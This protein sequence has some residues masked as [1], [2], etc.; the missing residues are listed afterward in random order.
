MAQVFLSYRHE[1]EEHRQRVLELGQ[2]LRAAGID[3]M[4]DQFFTDEHPGGPDEKWTRWSA[5]HAGTGKVLII[6][7]RGWFRCYKGTEAPGIGL[8]A[9][10]EASIIQERIYQSQQKIKD[11]RIVLL[12]ATDATDLPFE[13]A[14]IQQFKPLDM[15]GDFEAMC[16]WIEGKGSV[17]PTT[18]STPIE[19]LAAPPTFEWLLADCEPVHEAFSTLLTAGCTHGILLIRGGSETGKTSLTKCLLGIALQQR[20]LACGRL[21]LKGGVDLDAEYCRFVQNLGVD[22]GGRDATGRKLRERLDAVLAAVCNACKPTVF[23]F[24]AFEAGGVCAEW[25][26]KTALLAVPRAPW[27]RI[28]IAGQRVPERT[29]APWAHCAAPV[30]QLRPL[31]WRPW[32]RYGRLHWPDLTEEEAQKF[33]KRFKSKPPLL[34]QIFGPRDS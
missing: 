15:A 19:W 30:I 13:L 8:G 1:N 16:R 28:I 22:E 7:S 4:L 18:A 24:D 6:G 12:D 31:A 3:V 33:H 25:V 17:P 2:Q 23:I 20:W 14:G 27:L 10:L 9:A 32:Y 34:A 29:G 26:E 21:D 5:Q 11:I